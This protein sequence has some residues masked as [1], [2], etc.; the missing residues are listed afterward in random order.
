MN[1]YQGEVRRRGKTLLIVEGNHEKNRLF[2]LIF[3]C[4]QE[5]NINMDDVWIYGTNIYR[6]YEDIVREYGEE[7]AEENEDIDLPFVISRKQCP[8]RLQYKED[9]TNII[10]VF[11]YERHDTN[12]SEE[13]ITALQRSF[14]DA[15]NMGKLYINYPMIESYQHLCCLPDH[16]FAERK[17]P[18]SLQPG[19]K[20]KELVERETIFA[21]LIDFPHRID[22]LL[23][24]RF[25]V[26]DTEKRKGCCDK[27]LEI[28]S[29]NNIEGEVERALQGAISGRV[30]STAKYQLTDWIR[31]QDYVRTNQTYWMYMRK[32][33]LQVIYH[34]I[35]KANKIQYDQYQI[36]ENQ[37]RES[38]DRVD[39]LEILNIQNSV[40]R[41]SM[42]GFIWVLNTCVYFV[43]EY[44]FR[45]TAE[46]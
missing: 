45:L 37:Y 22:D 28:S 40:S 27:L 18:L 14:K 46:E 4:F 36:P 17:I 9:F 24:G 16:D 34:N 25:G 23:K 29:T 32:M 12:F 5:I 35:C 20:Y 30:F 21:P 13:K 6:L 26:N 2:W 11:D 7:W 43:A 15:A 44:N 39:P 1:N 41:D 33:L 19:K 3:R 42:E 38:F 10:L 31:S 8:D